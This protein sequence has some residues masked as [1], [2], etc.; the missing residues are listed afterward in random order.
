M[1]NSSGLLLGVLFGAVGL[2]YLTYGRRQKA[3]I[4][5]VVGVALCV[6]PYLISNVWVL[7]GVGVILAGVPYFMR[8]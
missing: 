8:I 3:V 5:L 1:G 2:G 7:I 6:L 4:P